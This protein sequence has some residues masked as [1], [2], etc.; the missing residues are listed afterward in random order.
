M[1]VLMDFGKKIIAVV[2]VY[3]SLLYSELFTIR[4]IP[5]F[6]FKVTLR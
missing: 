6:E 2:I 5:N 4:T 3:S 1:K